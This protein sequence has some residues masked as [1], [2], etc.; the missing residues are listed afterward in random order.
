LKLLVGRGSQMVPIAVLGI[1]KRREGNS[2]LLLREC[3]RSAHWP[4]IWVGVCRW[5]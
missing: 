3:C 1:K 2:A 5:V 4:Y